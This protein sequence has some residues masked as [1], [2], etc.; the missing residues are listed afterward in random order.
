MIAK[1]FHKQLFDLQTVPFKL[2][3]YL[4]KSQ[5]FFSLL[6]QVKESRWTYKPATT[7]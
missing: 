3:S 5:E 1:H 2:D 7:W 4:P 6:I